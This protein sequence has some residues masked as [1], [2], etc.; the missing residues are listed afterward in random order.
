MKMKSI[1]QSQSICQVGKYLWEVSLGPEEPFVSFPQPTIIAWSGAQSK[2]YSQPAKA[3]IMC[4]R[5]QAPSSYQILCS[6]LQNS[7]WPVPTIGTVSANLTR[8]PQHCLFPGLPPAHTGF[9]YSSNQSSKAA[10]S[11]AFRWD[12]LRI[13]PTISTTTAN[14]ADIAP[15]TP[16]LILTSAIALGP[17]AAYFWDSIWPEVVLTT[18]SVNLPK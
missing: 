10:L 16:W 2:F 12:S 6:L 8:W 9:S 17:S 15:T 14:L 4:T 1:Y 5:L 7:P 3:I 11:T 13:I 18:A